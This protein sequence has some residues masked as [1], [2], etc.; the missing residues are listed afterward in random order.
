MPL[1][2][3]LMRLS[4]SLRRGRRDDDLERELRSHLEM[5]ADD[6]RGRGVDADAAGRAARLQWGSAPFAI[7]S[8][9]DQRGL[10]WLDDLNGDV[11]YA[12]RTLRRSPGFSL[13]ALVTLALGIGANTAIFA[14]VNSVLLRPLVYPKPEQLMRLTSQFPVVGSAGTGL[15]HPEYDEFRRMTRSFAQLGAFTTGGTSQGGGSGVWAGEVNMTAGDRPIRVRS[16]AVDHHVFAVL[17]VQPAQGRFF[18]PGETDA[19]A[20]RPGLGGPPLAI[21]SHELWQS[22]FAGQPMVGQAVKVDGRPHDVIG[23]MPPDVDLMDARPEIWLPLGMHPVIR[24][25]RT[26]HL[27]SVVGRL[28]GGATPEAA[29]LELDTFVENWSDRTGASGH[30]PM[31]TPTR[32]EDHTL[33]LEPLQN[34]V[35]GDASRAI[36]LLQA[37]VGLVLLIGCANLANLAMARGESRRRE[38]AVRMALGAGRGRLLRQAMTEGGVL[39]LAG[40]AAGVSVAIAGID[41]LRLAYPRSLPRTAE[42]GLD[43]QV[44][45]FAFVLSVATGLVCALAPFARGRTRDL[46]QAIRH[47][48]DRGVAGGGRHRLRR[49]LVIAEV[50]LAMMLAAGAA[51]LLRTVVNLSRVDAGFDRRRLVTFA[52][53][54]PAG[55][56]Y[57]GGRARVYQRLLDTLRVAPGVQFATAMSHLPFDRNAQRLS[58]RVEK[59]PGTAPAIEFVDYYQFVMSDYFRAMGIPIVAGRGFDPIDTASADRVIVVNQAL[60]T[61]LWPGRSPI[62]QRLRPNLSATIGTSDNPWH[63]VIGVAKDGREA[64]VDRASGTLVYLFVDQPGPPIDGTRTPWVLTAPMTM[65]IAVRSGLSP[66]AL[67]ATLEAAVRT[68]D[69][70]VPIVRLREMDNVFAESIRRPTLLSLLLGGFAALALLLAA[71]GTYGVLSFLVTERRREVGIRMALGA[72]RT[73]VVALVLRQGLTLVAIGVAAG[74]SGA[75]LANRLLSSLLFGIRPTDAATLGV[76]AAT[77]VLVAALACVVPAW[78]ASRFDPSLVLKAE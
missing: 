24:T 47:G 59:D 52:M 58:T 34:A 1:R 3:W 45:L 14:I 37:G 78:R 8:L 33:R 19:M 2:E 27:L 41:G 21:L 74:V 30:V 63:T 32:P 77:I 36:W 43:I 28:G 10:P 48:G 61:R 53:T 29:Q 55:Q 39:S 42:I 26:S 75:L 44:L 5:A 64:G 18:A 71:V 65:H 23:I 51:L 72:A 20:S 15:S 46:V 54:L 69:P 6:V 38:F 49:G 76:V 73:G 40:G 12:L 68:A 60:A 50:A 16:A 4:G 17:G 57:A 67:A 25:I 62:G 7:E 9:R 31:R 22:A 13:V 66:A 11:R 70:A 35:V 56:D